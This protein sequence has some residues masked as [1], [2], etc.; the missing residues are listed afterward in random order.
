MA[1]G[2]TNV[3]AVRSAKIEI[4]HVTVCHDH[5]FSLNVEAERC[6][7]HFLNVTA[8]AVEYC[9]GTSRGVDSLVCKPV[10]HMRLIRFAPPAGASKR[11]PRLVHC[12]VGRKLVHA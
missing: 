8:A 6:A 1:Q 7:G 3:L 9:N 4:D 5:S 12:G 11:E 10:E 2:E